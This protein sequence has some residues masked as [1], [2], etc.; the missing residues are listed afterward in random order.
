MKIIVN[1][2]RG[3]TNLRYS[4]MGGPRKH[5]KPPNCIAL[6]QNFDLWMMF[7]RVGMVFFFEAMKGCNENLTTKFMNFWKKRNVSIGAMKL[8]VTT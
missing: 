4:K 8:E 1:Q 5:T 3:S 6:K 7:R 2:K